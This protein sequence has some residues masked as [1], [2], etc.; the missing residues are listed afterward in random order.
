M[1]IF[2]IVEN[3]IELLKNLQELTPTL[4]QKLLLVPKL[5]HQLAFGAEAL[6]LEEGL[7]QWISLIFRPDTYLA[8][9]M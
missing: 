3:Y 1:L 7:K 6:T 2:V 4:R 5:E 8:R 9:G